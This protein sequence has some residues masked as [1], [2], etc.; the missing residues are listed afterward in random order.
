LRPKTLQFSTVGQNAD[1]SNGARSET[2]K[3]SIKSIAVVFTKQRFIRMP[4]GIFTNPA[5]KYMWKKY[6][7]HLL[8][9]GH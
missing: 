7:N 8:P 4:F 6:M 9:D 2:T 5:K 1:K 3:V